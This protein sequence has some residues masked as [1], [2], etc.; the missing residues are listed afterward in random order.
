LSP[1]DVVHIALQMRSR[2][3]EAV[4]R[5]A[6]VLAEADALSSVP[7]DALRCTRVHGDY[8]LAQALWHEGD[9]TIIDF[10]GDPE[11]PLAVRRT[12]QSPLVDVAG[13]MR[14]F[15]YAAQVRLAAWREREPETARRLEPWADFWSRAAAKVFLDRY[16]TTART[17]AGQSSDPPGFDAVLRCLLIARDLEDLAREM[18]ERPSMA[19]VPLT[20]LDALLAGDGHRSF[21]LRR[22]PSQCRGT[23]PSSSGSS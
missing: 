11:V 14:A 6:A 15:M 2:A 19:T 16:R 12:L 1:D 7:L 10:E 8:H 23:P 18:R 22:R 17:L 13:M 9:F 3:A 21:R 5:E 4:G 20:A